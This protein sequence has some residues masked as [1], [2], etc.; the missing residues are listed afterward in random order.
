MTDL[1]GFFQSV[2]T[3]MRTQEN[4][5]AFGHWKNPFSRGETGGGGKLC[6]SL[7]PYH[8]FLEFRRPQKR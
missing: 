6:G 1:G 3:K 4:T 5:R 8:S 7:F 2:E